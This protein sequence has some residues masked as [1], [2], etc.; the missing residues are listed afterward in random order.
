[1]RIYEDIRKTAENRLPARSDY[2][3]GGRSVETPLNGEWKFC[4]YKDEA[5][6]KD[7]F[8]RDV[9]A[10]RVSAAG[11]DSISVP[12]C[13]QILGFEDPNYTNVNYPFPVDPPYVP[14]INPAGVYLKKFTLPER[15]GRTYLV[16]EGVSSAAFVYLNGI[17]VGR[18][19]GSHLRAEYDVTD[20]LSD[21]ENLLAVKVLKW[22]VGSYLEN[23]DQF[24]M[25]GIFRDVYLLTRPEGHLRDAEVRA[26]V[27][28]IRPG[29]HTA[30]SAV[31]TVS[32]ETSMDR[33]AVYSPE[34][35]LLS[36]TRDTENAAL[37][38]ENPRL[39]NAEDP[40]LYRV[41]LEKDGEVIPIPYGIRTIGFSDRSELLINGVSVKLRG[42]NHHDTNPRKGWYEDEE[43]FTRELLLMK[44]LNV[45][46]IRTSHYPPAPAFMA[47]CDRLGFYVVLET[48]IETHGFFQRNSG[49]ERRYDVESPDWPCNRPEWEG[50]FVDR[51]VRAER[52]YRNHASVIM[53]SLGNESGAGPNHKAMADYLHSLNDGRPVHYEG[54][55]F[56]EMN[57]YTDVYSRMYPTLDFVREYAEDPKRTQP[58]FLCEYAHAM[59]PGP[60]D[61]YAYNEL[62]NRYPK[63]IGGCIWEWADHAVIRDGKKLYGGDF[64]SELTNNR[65]FCC[66]GLVFC[67][68]SIR[69]G[70]LEVKAVFQPMATAWDP[71]TGTL[72]V[73]NRFDFTDFTAYAFTYEVQE[74]G[75]TVHTGA[76]SLT[77]PPHEA[78]SFVLR[79]PKEN[80]VRY[81]RML[82]CVLKNPAGETVAETEHV[83]S[84][85][86]SLPEKAEGQAEIEETEEA[87]IFLGEGFRYTLS[88]RSGEFV[89]LVMDGEE[90]L[91]F[92]QRLSAWRPPIDN[93]RYIKERWNG[94][95]GPS[96][97]NIDRTFENT[98]EVRLLGAEVLVVSA[99]SGISR[100]PYF[101][102]E[103]RISVSASGKVTMRIDGRVRE[104]APY[105]PRLGFEWV[106]PASSNEFSYYA[107]GPEETYCDTTHGT[108]RGLYV[109]D[110][111]REYVPYPRPQDHGNH[112]GAR[113]LAIGRM[114]FE[115]D[116]E[117]AVSEYSPAMLT[118]AWHEFELQKDGFIHLR[119]DYRDSGTGSGSCGPQLAE[120]FQ[121]KEKEISFAISFEKR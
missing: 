11:W 92:P 62:F 112:F 24:R 70:S 90:Q 40:V 118:K 17:F 19:Q 30:E 81:G 53:W 1:M 94:E 55:S 45:N 18:S 27:Q 105:L 116:F 80:A 63:L 49:K 33:V 42:V 87:F 119:T 52:L 44:S 3:P 46:C 104:D 57:D 96:G 91:A 97:E 26:S 108:F 109:S 13:W 84:P 66:D 38:I 5:S 106:L 37:P 85:G 121:V 65:N 78:G 64:P 28:G 9:E 6:V 89:S 21:G 74:D 72:T 79:L 25:N 59:G 16:F 71:G 82:R 29:G 23:Q 93:D 34:G 69:P 47:L 41:I 67:D 76:L 7:S 95:N 83:L 110:A 99:L 100:S 86:I 73:L 4:F 56:L 48:D 68:R 60:G 77:I 8:L 75:K 20:A 111:A 102:Y 107:Y 117:F 50:E 14:E 15:F 39:W 120:E 113:M 12:S 98:R 103:K 10:L 54:A 114:K 58:M 115:G 36:E 35:E 31:L 51:M 101:I 32:S 22:C 61:A 43:D 88:K 2:R